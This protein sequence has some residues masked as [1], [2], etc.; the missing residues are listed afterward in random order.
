MVILLTVVEATMGRVGVAA[1]KELTVAIP[2]PKGR[3]PEDFFQGGGIQ[4]LEMQMQM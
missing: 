4:S 3:V 2:I 1:D